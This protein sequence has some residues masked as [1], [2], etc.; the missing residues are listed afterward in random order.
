M[1][2]YKNLKG[3]KNRTIYDALVVIL[4]RQLQTDGL[5]ALI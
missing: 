1:A 4:P 3:R 5:L 2:K